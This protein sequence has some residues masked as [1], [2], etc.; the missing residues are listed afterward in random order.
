MPQTREHILLARQVEVPAMVVFMNK[1]DMVDDEELL[2]LVELEVR[3]LLSSYEFPG[4]DIP[5]VQGSARLK[6]MEGD[7]PTV[8][9]QIL[10]LMEARWTSTF[11][12]RSVRRGQAV[13]D[14]C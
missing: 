13:P 8:K 9:Q 10:E 7:Q 3:E 6:A 5:I 14:A 11:R 4:D 12:S 1:C 2:E